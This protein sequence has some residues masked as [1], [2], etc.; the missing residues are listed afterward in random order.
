MSYA[1]VWLDAAEDQ[2]AA[3]YLAARERGRPAAVTTAAARAEDL[4]RTNPGVCGESRDRHQRYLPA[5]PLGI[6]YE[7]HEDERVVVVVNVS[8]APPRR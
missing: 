5:R 6:L 3:A 8:Y 7:L 4:L 1:V 2:L